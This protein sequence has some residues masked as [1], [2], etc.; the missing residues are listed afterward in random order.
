MDHKAKRGFYINAAKKRKQQREQQEQRDPEQEPDASA[1]Q[2]V[3]ELPRKKPQQREQSEPEHTSGD[4][5]TTSGNT[6]NTESNQMDIDPMDLGAGAPSS[7]GGA[8]AGHNR[9]ARHAHAG[10]SSSA[11]GGSSSAGVRGT[12]PLWSGIRQGPQLSTRVYKKEYLFRLVNE[13]VEIQCVA[14]SNSTN[15]L[16]SIRYPFHD[17]PVNMLGFYLSKAEIKELMRFTRC[18]VESVNVQ[19]YN[20]TGCLNFETASST[21]N[22]GNNNVGIYLCE[23]SPD[24]LN[25]RTGVLPNQGIF[26]HE[27]CWGNASEGAANAFAWSNSVSGLGAQYVRRNMDNKFEYNTYQ[28]IQNFG[29]TGTAYNHGLPYFNINPFIDK[30]VNASMTEGLFTNYSYKPKKGLVAGNFF[31]KLYGHVDNA[32][33]HYVLKNGHMPLMERHV[34]TS[35][36]SKFGLL[37][38]TSGQAATIGSGGYTQSAMMLG[39]FTNYTENDYENIQLDD[40]IFFGKNVQPPL[41]IGIEPLTTSLNDKWEAVKAFVDITIHVEL[42]LKIQQGV[43]YINSNTESTI[44]PDFQNPEYVPVVADGNNVLYPLTA[45]PHKQGD[46]EGHVSLAHPRVAEYSTP[47]SNIETITRNKRETETKYQDLLKAKQQR[48]ETAE[49]DRMILRSHTSKLKERVENLESKH[50]LTVPKDL[51]F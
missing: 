12:V 45:P 3:G 16:R 22:I 38:N 26:I 34:D 18:E 47:K 33:G 44:I 51:L 10:S 11:G 24:I 1:E 49:Y 46:K 43:D 35:F 50:K 4:N 29:T 25:K 23:L 9:H 27:K 37:S 36:Q 28:Q 7:A 17:I 48:I 20:K 42:V 41:I 21:S 40:P 39:R 15:G 8:S 2:P 14:L 19:I 13:A 32:N 6:E 31:G 30:R 5:P